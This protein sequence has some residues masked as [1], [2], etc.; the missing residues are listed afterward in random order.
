MNFFATILVATLKIINKIVN[1]VAD[2]DLRE[3]TCATAFV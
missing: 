1:S 2:A 3:G